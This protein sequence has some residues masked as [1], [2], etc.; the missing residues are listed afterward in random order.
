[1]Q[2]YFGFLSKEYDSYPF[3]NQTAKKRLFYSIQT[4]ASILNSNRPCS[5]SLVADDMLVW[6][7][8]LAFLSDPKFTASLEPYLNDVAIRARVWR[9][10]TLCWAAHSCLSLDGDYVDIGCYDGHTVDV[11]ERYCDFR[12]LASKKYWLYDI[13]DSPPDESRKPSHGPNL[14]GLV[15]SLFASCPNFRIIKGSIPESFL[16]GLPERIAFAQID[17]NSAEADMNAFEAIYDR[18]T[19][20]AIV[21][22]DD[23]GYSRYKQTCAQISTFAASKFHTLLESP[24]MQGIF[25]KR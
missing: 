24:T 11:I 15:E 5:S 18:L 4:A 13:F 17:L 19:T 3:D 23:Y 25:I 2:P 14:L 7:R 9:V 10:Y 6:F 1:M 20:G 16:Q 8:N 22:F 12:N 21:I